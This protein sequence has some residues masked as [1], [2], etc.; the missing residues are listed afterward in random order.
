MEKAMKTKEMDCQETLGKITS[1]LQGKLQLQEEIDLIRHVEHCAS[2]YEEL[3]LNYIM[4]IGLDRLDEEQSSSMDFTA[5]LQE[6]LEESK[7]QYR[8]KRRVLCFLYCG[9]A[10]S[11]LALLGILGLIF[12][13]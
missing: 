11:V 7:R 2:C 4:L 10:G 9:L 8:K 6:Y 13:Q 12:L 5:M 3:E 1:Y